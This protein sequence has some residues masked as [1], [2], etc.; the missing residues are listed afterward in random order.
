MAVID[1]VRV[2]EPGD[3]DGAQSVLALRAAGMGDLLAA[4]PA[5]RALAEVVPAGPGPHAPGVR[6]AAPRWLHPLVELIPGVRGAV[7][8]AGLTPN[9]LPAG[10]VVVNLH[11]SGP[12]SHA[13]LLAAQ[14]TAML[15]FRSEP[16][17]QAG[18]K[19]SDAESER[20]RWCRLLHSV[21]VAG[22]PRRVELLR[23][24]VECRVPEAL[25]L[26]VGASDEARRWPADRYV[27][28]ARALRGG[29]VVL[30]GTAADVPVAQWVAREAGLHPRA[31]LAGRLSLTRLAA[32]VAQARLV[33]STDT[34]VA[35]LASAYRIPSVVVFGPASPTRWAPPAEGP[36]R[37]VRAAGDAPAAAQ[38]PAQAVLDHVTDLLRP[39]AAA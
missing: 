16:V 19:W 23:P 10:R 37:V 33:V 4:V 3:L 6:V 27:E 2:I 15:A 29:P 18:P 7:G 39:A 14:P 20:D 35:H 1:R 8:V 22:D 11:G 9:W 24:H 25:V 5:L 26:H 12:Q 30:T 28:I 31:V 17:W 13:A 21:G 34:G 38:V 32:L 36:H